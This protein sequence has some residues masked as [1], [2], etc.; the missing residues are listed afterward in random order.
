MPMVVPNLQTR[1]VSAAG[2][3][4]RSAAA[5]AAVLS[6]ALLGWTIRQGVEN[7]RESAAA[8]QRSV[9]VA[10]LR[11]SIGY[12]DGWLS[13]S[14]RLA[15]ASG[16]RRWADLYAESVPKLDAA[17]TEALAIATPEVRAAMTDTTEEAHRDL[18]T[19]ERRALD[20]VGSGDL[21]AARALLDSPEFTYLENV[22]SAGLDT[23]GQDLKTL[24]ET[25]ASDL[26][27]RI[28]IEAAA[29]GLSAILVVA[30]GLTVRGHVRLR[31]A[32]ARTETVA[33]TDALTE[34]PNRRHFYEVLDVSLAG[35]VAPGFRHALL[36]LD[37][38]RFKAANDAYGHP[39]GDRLLKRVAGR[40]RDAVGPTDTVARLGGDEFAV[41]T[42]V[43]GTSEDE[44]TGG[45]AGDLAGRLIAALA[46]PF[47]LDGGVVVEVGASIGIALG[48][49]NTRNVDHIMHRAD[50]ALYRAKA[51]GR[52]CF[53]VFA[54]DSDA[55]VRSLA[56][57][58]GELR[59]AVATDAI[60]PYYQPLVSLQTGTWVGVELLARWA[61]PTRGMI[62]PAEFIPLAEEAGLIGSLTDRM[63]RRACRAAAS[64]PGE[65]V[66]ACN[67]SPV[68]LRDPNLPHLVEDILAETG[69][70]PHRLELEVTEGALVGDVALAKASLDALKS[71]GV[72]LALDDFG[73]GYSSLRS[74]RAFPFDK[75]KIDASFVGTM[76]ADRES[77]KIVAAVINLSR[78][79][80]LETVAEGVETE[81]TASRL[82][83]LGCDI[84]QGWLFGRPAP[85]L[86]TAA[87][88]LAAGEARETAL[89]S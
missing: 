37:L 1:Y 55:K 3:L 11:G 40:L 6:L 30:I 17:V 39:A 24:A 88:I 70:Q 20:L 51:D 89:A 75:L 56:L 27:K 12:L 18:I 76:V 83:A 79:L 77:D 23:F 59:K 14:A 10:E 80:G 60:E 7:Y 4:R 16:D 49:A 85:E 74:L 26:G 21:P 64:W 84:G 45:D 52:G 38:D 9:R 35:P 46:R 63:M 31:R 69:L 57:L 32:M 61:H 54:Q 41:W 43:V 82:R 65:I 2:A 72:R 19:M 33:R 22:S 13:M 86:V 5:A 81:V 36:L 15:A 62:S 50:A 47:D 71:R 87:R 78:S 34:L 25:R 67:L 68:H 53:R 73:T 8:F 48:G 44:A 66:L 28:W 29:L 42:R 58:A